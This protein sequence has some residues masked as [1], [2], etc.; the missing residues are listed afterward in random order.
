MKIYHICTDS[1]FLNSVVKNFNATGTE[2][3]FC[4]VS[5]KLTSHKI[6]K[7]FKTPEKL[8]REI[9]EKADLVIIHSLCVIPKKLL[10][11]NKVGCTNCKYCMP[12][13]RNVDIPGVFRIYNN[14][15]MYVNVVNLID[16]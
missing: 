14:Y 15:A 12:C 11:I 3:V 1:V 10:K 16:F 4:T 8:C 13:P 9:N 7:I 6:L 2:N 5:K